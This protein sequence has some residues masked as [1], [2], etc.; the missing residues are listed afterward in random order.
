MNFDEKCLWLMMGND[1]VMVIVKPDLIVDDEDKPPRGGDD[2]PR[3]LQNQ[4]E[5]STVM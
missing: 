2:S 1:G 3:Q 4:V 5:M